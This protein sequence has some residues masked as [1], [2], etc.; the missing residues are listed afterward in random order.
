M[1]A[2]T[3]K[4]LTNFI[5]YV[6]PIR[7]INRNKSFELKIKSV[8]WLLFLSFFFFFLFLTSTSKP[9]NSNEAR[10]CMTTIAQTK[11]TRYM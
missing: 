7:E 8:F 3:F 5:Y 4:A 11:S 2:L 6:T 10:E 1:Q 9:D